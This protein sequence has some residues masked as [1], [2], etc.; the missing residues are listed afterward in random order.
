M[1]KWMGL[2]VATLLT[3]NVFAAQY[4]LVSS[5]VSKGSADLCAETM[6]FTLKRGVMTVESQ[7]EL[8]SHFN[9]DQSGDTYENL[10]ITHLNGDVE[11]K[12]YKTMAHGEHVSVKR[13]STLQNNVLE[14]QIATKFGRVLYD[15][16]EGY[17]KI[18]F[19][20]NGMD[21]QIER[22]YKSLIPS[23][24]NWTSAQTCKY[25]LVK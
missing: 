11:K 17:L 25:A 20:D 7:S 15:I 6:K 14:I 13:K 21:V 5:Q 10:Q 12:S 2:V 16:A 9:F 4:T 8:G 1:L 22:S 18:S 23:S 24:S 3:G 19:D